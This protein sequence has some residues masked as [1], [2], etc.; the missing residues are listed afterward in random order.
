MANNYSAAGFWRGWH[1]SYNQWLV[2]WALFALVYTLQHLIPARNRYIYI[3]IGGRGSGILATIL[4]FTFVALWHDLSFKLLTWGWLIS[5]F[6]LPEML[7]ARMVTEE[8]VRLY[9]PS[10]GG[11]LMVPHIV[12]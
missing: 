9:Q 8:K 7:L 1:R 4:V 12:W 10:A 5:L 6:I 3:P 2:R 11:V